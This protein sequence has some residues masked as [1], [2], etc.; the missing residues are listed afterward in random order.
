MEDLIITLVKDIR[1]KQKRLG[2]RKLLNM[3]R[4]LMPYAEQI[5]RDAFFDLLRD[6]GML[7][8]KRRTRAYTTNS[9][10]WLHKYPN[11]KYRIL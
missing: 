5:G 9:S 7:V 3:I 11:L 4:G 8:R 1:M 10:H 6:N 2:G